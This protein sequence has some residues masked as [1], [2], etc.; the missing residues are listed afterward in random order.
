M[1]QTEVKRRQ[2]EAIANILMFVTIYVMGWLTG[3]KGITYTAVGVE[4]CAVL[5]I[6][7]SGNLSDSLGRLLR[8][9]KNKG[10]YRNMAK[11][12]S[13]VMLFQVILGLA[14]SLVLAGMSSILAG[15]LFRIS[16]SSLILLVL[17]PLVLFRTVSAVLAGYFQ[18]EGSEFPRAIAGILRQIFLLGFGILFCHLLGDYGERVGRLLRQENFKAMYGGLGIALAAD[19]SELLVILFLGLIYKRSGRFERKAKQEGMYTADS[20]WD[21]VRY[22]WNARWLSF[23]TTLCAFLPIVLGLLFYGRN[24]EAPEQM[25]VEY[26]LYVGK[27][28]VIVGIGTVLIRTSALSIIGKTFQCFKREEKP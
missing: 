2:V 11:M 18:G 5:W 24:T 4:L 14:G 16:Y 17:S 21:S 27:Y 23:V 10:Q 25:A 9:R 7:I 8:S 1:N 28:L 15:K 12:R 3:D 20:L 6:G 22:L 26:G 13:N 19:I